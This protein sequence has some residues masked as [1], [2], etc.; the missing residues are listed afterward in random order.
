MS[1][2]EIRD[3]AVPIR[4]LRNMLRRKR[5]PNG[6]LF[7]GAGGV[8]KRMAALTMT[9]ALNCT[10]SPDDACGTCLA[11][12]KIT[13]GNHPDVRIVAPLR[14]AR[15]I[16]VETIEG[17]N[18]FAALRAFESE[19]RVFII[20]EA[21]RMNL[22]AQNHFLKTLEEPPGKSLFM[23]VSEFPRTL[24]PTIRSRCQQIRF[25]TLQPKTVAEILVRDRDLPPDVAESIA[26]LSQGQMS[27]ALDLVDSE[28][29]AVVLDVARQLAQGMDPLALAGEF[30]QHLASQREEIAALIKGDVDESL[31]A[32]ATREDKERLKAEEKARIDAASR[33]DIMEYL[34]L[35]E[36]WYRDV[37]VYGLCGDL[38]RVLNRDQGAQLTAA[39]AA[40]MSDKLAAIEKARI[41]LERFLNEE[42]VF[43]DLFFALAR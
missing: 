39:P 22:A 16:D 35:F 21:E 13:H 15:I 24:L 20:L 31:L 30:A 12:R 37:S 14:K 26:G 8:G 40:D 38:S 4:L 6:L 18:E 10:E 28:K 42:R 11:C 2:D 7:W 36:T 34:Y 9:R 27:R 41:Y 33:R 5:V 1:F 43:R 17:I 25:G 3:Q 19:W 29:R 32:E 23:L